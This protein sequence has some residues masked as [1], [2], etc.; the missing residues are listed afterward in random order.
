MIN[1]NFSQNSVLETPSFSKEHNSESHLSTSKMKF[2]QY[3]KP[4]GGFPE[5]LSNVIKGNDSLLPSSQAVRETEMSKYTGTHARTHARDD[6][7][8]LSRARGNSLG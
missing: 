6:P 1:Y 3:L 7:E 8:A 5:T 2:M 4:Q